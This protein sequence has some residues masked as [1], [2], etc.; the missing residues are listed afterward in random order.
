MRTTVDIADS[1]LKRAKR[2]ASDRDMRLSQIVNDAL[3]VLLHETE[4]RAAKREPFKMPN[5]PGE[6]NP[7]IDFTSNASIQAALDEEFRDPKSGE[8]DWARMR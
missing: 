4:K 2:Y 5:F 7:A 1:V 6:L 3:L 8:L